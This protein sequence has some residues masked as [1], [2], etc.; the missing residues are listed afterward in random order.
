M[1]QISKNN[2]LFNVSG[3]LITVGNDSK[4]IPKKLV[5]VTHQ[6]NLPGYFDFEP[7][8]LHTIY[9][10]DNVWLMWDRENRE[11]F[12]KHGT[13]GGSIVLGRKF[14]LSLLRY[15]LPDFSKPEL[16]W[17]TFTGKP[18]INIKTRNGISF[19]TALTKEVVPKK[20]FDYW[21]SVEIV[22]QKYE[23]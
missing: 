10:Y 15:G 3:F 21:G 7:K 12:Y 18:L 23:I 19:G 17:E 14:Y 20:R 11:R 6:V 4:T 5:N 2:G 9:D 8:D 22:K 13:T 1:R 16:K